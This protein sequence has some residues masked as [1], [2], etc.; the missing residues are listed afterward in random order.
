ME[1][2][3][4]GANFGQSLGGSDQAILRKRVQAAKKGIAWLNKNQPTIIAG[5]K[6]VRELKKGFEKMLKIPIYQSMLASSW[7]DLEVSWLPAAQS[8]KSEAQ[9]LRERCEDVHLNE[10][11]ILRDL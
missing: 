3:L 7:L 11:A 2:V 8:L 4:E 10:S 6:A 5:A 9:Q 1:Q